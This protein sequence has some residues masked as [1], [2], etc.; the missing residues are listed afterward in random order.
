MDINIL[1]SLADILS[2]GISIFAL[3][4]VNQNTKLIKQKIKGNNNIQ[5]GRDSNVR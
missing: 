4:K 2:L 5:S 3:F 1:G